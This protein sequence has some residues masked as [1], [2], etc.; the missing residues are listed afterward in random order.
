MTQEQDKKLTNERISRKD[1]V[2][3][4]WHYWKQKKGMLIISLLF[5]TLAVVTD[6]F[7]P[8]LTG[9]LVNTVMEAHDKQFEW[10]SAVIQA[11]VALMCLE[12]VYHLFRYVAYFLWNDFAIRNLYN[13]LNDSFR[14]V[15]RFSTDWHG[16]SYSGATVR[17]ITRGMWAFDQYEDIIFLYLYGTGIMLVTTISIMYIKW[18]IMGVVTL[19][20]VIIYV[21]VSVA[22]VL[23]INS[24]R[25]VASAAADTQVGAF[26]ADSITANATVKT[27]GRENSEDDNFHVITEGWRAKARCAWQSAHTVDL[28][29]RFMAMAMM[30]LM[31]YTALHLWS[32]GRATAGDVVYVITAFIVLSNYLRNIGEQLSNLQKAISEMEDIITFWKKKSDVEDYEGAQELVAPE[33]AICFEQVNFAYDENAE[34]IYDAF[35]IDIKSG[36]QVAL[37]GHSGSGKSTFVKLVQR[38]YDIQGGAI[39]IDGQNIAD[40]T[41]ESLRKTIALVPQEPIL[42]HRTL[43]DNIAYGLPGA[44]KGA[45]VKA[46]KQ[47]YAHDFIS[48]LPQGYD[49]LVGERGVKLSGGERQRVAIARAIL[50]NCPI[51][52]LDEATSALDSVSE[53]EI[54][55][56]L[57]TL[58]HGRTT[59]TI[60]HRLATIKAVDR[61]LVFEDGHVIE[62]G[63]HDELVATDGSQY[64]RLY[65][66]QALDL[67]G[68]RDVTK[69][70]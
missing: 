55:K 64:K 16:N 11:L 10:G 67:I 27:F 47:A 35:S 13:I 25:F 37:V 52:V 68:T 65:E 3:F 60:A 43:S 46:A 34:K 58:M 56:A 70:I 22:L 40:V 15:Q 9:A 61:I 69:L 8:I 36:E 1:I 62:Q 45:I 59:I 51:L 24:P 2:A 17:K 26:M 54:Q 66:M 19:S 32:V 29:R 4:T 21:L 49:T 57:K 50:T 12:L 42:F 7:F 23:R 30:G 18:P 63:T 31:I 53:H 28:V 20:C 39:T 38:L 6:T 44:T 41:Q 48:R 5:M 14:K 33:G